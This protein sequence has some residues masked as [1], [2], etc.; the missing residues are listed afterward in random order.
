MFKWLKRR[1][2]TKE[3]IEEASEVAT[4]KPARQ[5]CV[6]LLTQLDPTRFE[7]YDPINQGPTPI[8]TL[9]KTVAEHVDH[10]NV[11]NARLIKKELLAA[12]VRVY[13]THALTVDQFFAVDNGFYVDPAKSIASFKASALKL[14]ELLASSDNVEVGDEE[15][16]LRVLTDHLVNIREITTALLKISR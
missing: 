7:E 16:N 6:K 14:C 10:I 8:R 3:V 4:N 13:D 2:E 12:S 15:W 1:R 5:V 11:I 9:Y